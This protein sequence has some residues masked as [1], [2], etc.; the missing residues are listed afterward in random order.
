MVVL[1]PPSSKRAHIRVKIPPTSMEATI[2]G[3][4]PRWSMVNM[5]NTYAG[6][7]AKS[8][9]CE[10]LSTTDISLHLPTRLTKMK[11][12]KMSSLRLP[13]AKLTP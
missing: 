3:F 13:L 10:V 7:S 2:R 1:S 11:L 6:T 12:T 8:F 5:Q 9:L 4:L